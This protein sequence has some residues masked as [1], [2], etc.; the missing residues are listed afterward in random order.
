MNLRWQSKQNREG[1]D[2]V[3]KLCSA[4]HICSENLETTV[5]SRN[6]RPIFVHVTMS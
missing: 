4:N 6:G 2:E 5:G 1:G 3:G